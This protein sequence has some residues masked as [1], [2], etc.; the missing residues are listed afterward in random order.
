[1]LFSRWDSPLP[2]QT[3]GSERYDALSGFYCRGADV[4]VVCFDLT[5][6][7]SLSNVRK[8]VDKLYS[9]LPSENCQILLVGTKHD[10]AEHSRQVQPSKAQSVRVEIGAA[11][12]VETSAKTNYQI[13]DVFDMILQAVDSKAGVPVGADLGSV[14]GPVASPGVSPDRVKKSRESR[15]KNGHC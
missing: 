3:A 8:W 5:N 14:G 9:S 12:F 4:A 1:M 11:G 7:D 2:P 10:L 13:R 6:S 15:T